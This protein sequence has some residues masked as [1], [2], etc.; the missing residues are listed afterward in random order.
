M[1]SRRHFLV[2]LAVT[3]GSPAVL[4]GRAHAQTPPPPPPPVKLEITDP[5]AVAL[6][7]NPDTTKV[8]AQKYPLHTVEQKCAGCALYQEKP[9]EESAPCTIFQGKLTPSN[10]WCSAWAKKPDLPK[11]ELPK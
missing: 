9:G 1:H 4:A 7:F 3:L 10:G 5:V 2:K 11:P 8:D 6:G